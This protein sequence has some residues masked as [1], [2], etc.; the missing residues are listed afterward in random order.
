MG[1]LGY[2]ESCF[3]HDCTHSL[4][5]VVGMYGNNM[6]ANDFPFNP[7]DE[8]GNIWNAAWYLRTCLDRSNNNYEKALT[9]YK[10][11]SPKGARQAR[12]VLSIE[13]KK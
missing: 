12:H 2:T 1:K 9:Y 11:Y 4:P 10:G 13:P 6:K 3:D 7:F 8:R 5:Y